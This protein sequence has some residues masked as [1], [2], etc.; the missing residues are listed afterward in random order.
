MWP[1]LPDRA[2]ITLTSLTTLATFPQLTTLTTLKKLT[3]FKAC[4]QSWNIN[5]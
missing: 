5:F 2:Q 1:I 3:T 4:I